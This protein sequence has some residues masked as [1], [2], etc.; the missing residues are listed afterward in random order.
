MWNLHNPEYLGYGK[1]WEMQDVI[2]QHLSRWWESTRKHF[3]SALDTILTKTREEEYKEL[4][5][6]GSLWKWIEVMI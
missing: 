5:P 2:L 3:S 4:P 6:E 1:N